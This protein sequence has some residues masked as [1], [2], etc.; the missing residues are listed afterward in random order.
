MSVLLAV[1]VCAPS[2]PVTVTLPSTPAGKPVTLIVTVPVAAV[3]HAPPS[4]PELLP[5]PDPD[6]PHA[7]SERDEKATREA[8]RAFF[9]MSVG[10]KARIFIQTAYLQEFLPARRAASLILDLRA[11]WPAYFPRTFGIPWG[12]GIRANGHLRP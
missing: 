9:M 2:G 3:A 12:C 8:R 1:T 6:D 10:P 11:L 7:T 4:P 5:L